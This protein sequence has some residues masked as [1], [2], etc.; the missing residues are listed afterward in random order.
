MKMIMMEF[1]KDIVII[2][3]T[4]NREKILRDFWSMEDIFKMKISG[5]SMD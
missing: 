2:G 4:M 3:E 5:R 1:K